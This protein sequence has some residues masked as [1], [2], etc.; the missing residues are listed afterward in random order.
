MDLLLSIT[1]FLGIQAWLDTVPYQ[2][3]LVLCIL[4]ASLVLFIT[5]KFSVDLVALLVL[6]SLL[7]TGLVPQQDIL[8]GFSSPATITVASMF[9]LSAGLQRTGVVR[10]IAQKIGILAGKGKQ[11][12]SVVLQVTCGTMSAFINNT[13]AVAVLLPVALSLSKER[14]INPSKVLM[15]LSFSAQFGGVCTLIGTSTNLLVNSLAKDAG[16][17]GFS[18]FEFTAMGL[19]CFAVGMVYM[20]FASV[21]LMPDREETDSV[22][23]EYRLQDYLTEM[24]VMK[25]S[26]LIGQTVAESD[27]NEIGE[28][29]VLEIIRDK[30][31]I[32]APGATVIKEGDILLMRCD[33]NT[34][35]EA[36]DRLKLENWADHKLT[37]SHAKSNEISMAEVIVPTQSR[38]VGRTLA[39][40]DFYWRYHAAV[41]GVRRRG[42]VL[43]ERLSEVRFQ[44]GDT[45]LLQGHQTDLAHL[46]SEK[47][48]ILL[49]SLSDLRLRKHRAFTAIAIIVGVVGLAALGVASILTMAMVGVAAM[50][51]SRCLTVN[52]A[53]ESIDMK[54]IVL[55]AG[56]IPLGYAMAHTGTADIIVDFVLGTIG[57]DPL[58]AM[59]AIYALTMVLTAVISNNA[60]AVLLAP[61]AIST[62]TELGVSPTPFLVAITFAA[63][64]CFT[65]PVG[66]QTNTMVY[67]PGGY[68]YTDFVR[69]GLPLNIILF[70]VTVYLIPLFWPF[71]AQ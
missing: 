57:K 23:Q 10:W 16:L 68:K 63:S 53:Y 31:M 60:T 49:Q 15:P 17:T 71:T 50:V 27:L 26:A 56:M 37:D 28:V 70:G 6:L 67:G 2:P 3:L 65:T 11:R 48:F 8:A 51:I 18:M 19:I 12:M 32:W 35:I 4:T 21:F 62:A 5:E 64:T 59:A 61:I 34:L 43:K 41:L 33:A 40:L 9:I 13:A 36:A 14:G 69:I 66:Y 52:E 54:V 7:I 38:L 44:I 22:E 47:D 45:L 46:S 1:Q 20:L 39:Q 24:R 25:A 55:L 29:K 30:K 58:T 42:S